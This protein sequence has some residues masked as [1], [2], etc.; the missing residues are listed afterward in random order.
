MRILGTVPAG[1][2]KSSGIHFKP[3]DVLYGRLRPYLNKVCRPSFEGVCSAEFIVLP[4]NER[5][6]GAYL[7]YFLN[8]ASFVRYSSRLNAGDRPRVDFDQLAPHPIPLRPRSEQ[9]RIVAEI[10]KQFSR[11]DEAVA[12]LERAKM[13]LKHY[14]AAILRAAI[15]GRLVRNELEIAQG[16]ARQ[17]EGAEELLADILSFR[18]ARWPARYEPPVEPTKTSREALPRGWV[19]C[20]VSQLMRE[21]I[22]NGLSVKES[23]MPTEVRALRLN[24]MSEAGFDYGKYRYLP[25]DRTRVEDIVVRES[26]FFVCRGNGTLDL[27]GRGT[28][29][30]LPPFDV[31]FPDTMMRVRFVNRDIGRWI[32]LLWPSR[33][34]RAQIETR[35]KTTA[36][37]YK[38]AQPQLASI[39]LPLPPLS[40]MT[41]IVSE[42]NRLLSVVGEISG[43]IE[44]GLRRGVSLKQGILQSAFATDA[45]TSRGCGLGG[46]RR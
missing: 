12:N 45:R 8:S 24:A 26:D 10:Q 6:D 37:I 28:T 30:Q 18:R 32:G 41:R 40:E 16:A 9:R 17:C 31:I 34:V 19:W 46:A 7:Q 27:V 36:G 42:V 44:A 15:E 35:V 43:E 33:L 1:T 21:R 29:A 5:V 38:I 25:V 39:T 20:T 2:M 11:V 13:K 4:E 22:I 23:P 3:G 14:R